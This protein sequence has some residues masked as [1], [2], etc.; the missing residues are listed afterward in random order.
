MGARTAV[1]VDLGSKKTGLAVALEGVPLPRSIVPTTQ[2][3][4]AIIEL[5]LEIGATDIVIGLPDACYPKRREASEML[6]RRILT[7][8]RGRATPFQKNH[9]KLHLVDEGCTTFEA[10]SDA[11]EDPS[12]GGAKPARDDAAAAAILGRW[13]AQENR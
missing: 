10:D 12:Y 8:V 9:I 5:A 3:E 13:L 6:A 2:A 7:R 1:G 4:E 11:T